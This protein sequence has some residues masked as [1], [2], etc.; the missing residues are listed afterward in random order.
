MI[1][2]EVLEILEERMKALDPNKKDVY[3]FIGC[4]KGGN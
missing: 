2:G 4:E 3:K 1:K